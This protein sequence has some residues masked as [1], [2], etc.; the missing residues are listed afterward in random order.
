MK[1]T[2]E[3][4]D[5]FEKGKGVQNNTVTMIRGVL[6]SLFS[7]PLFLCLLSVL[8]FLVVAGLIPAVREPCKRTAAQVKAMWVIADQASKERLVITET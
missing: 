8:V 1:E 2:E 5:T 4:R 7:S 3:T 6:F